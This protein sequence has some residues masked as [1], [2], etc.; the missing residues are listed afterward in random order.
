[1]GILIGIAIAIAIVVLLAKLGGSTEIQ[2]S[3]SIKDIVKAINHGRIHPYYTGMK[4]NDVVYAVNHIYPNTSEFRQ[5]LDMYKLIGR[6]PAIDLPHHPNPYIDRISIGFNRSNI[7]SSISIYIKDFEKNKEGLIRE[8]ATKFG[9]P[10]SS[11]G[12]FI[13]WRDRHR[14]INISY[15]GSISVIDEDLFGF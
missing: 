2:K 1:M 15:N 14:V 3:N 11:D 8:M 5:E 13:I 10:M 7:V 6:I 4:L 12:Q 9:R